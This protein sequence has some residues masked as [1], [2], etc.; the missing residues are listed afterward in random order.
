MP[1]KTHH[2]IIALRNILI[3]QLANELKSVGLEFGSVPYYY[4]ILS[5]MSK[6]KLNIELKI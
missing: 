3:L 2:A 1:N 4:N 6:V 5:Q